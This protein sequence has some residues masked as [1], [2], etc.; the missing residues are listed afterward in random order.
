MLNRAHL[1]PW[2]LQH[3]ALDLQRRREQHHALHIT[4]Q[5]TS[6]RHPQGTPTPPHRLRCSPAAAS[7]AGCRTMCPERKIRRSRCE[8]LSE[9]QSN[10]G[11]DRQNQARSSR[12]TPRQ[13]RARKKACVQE[14]KARTKPQQEESK[15][16]RFALAGVS[17]A[18]GILPAMKQHDAGRGFHMS[19]HSNSFKRID[20]TTPCGELNEASTLQ[21][22]QNPHP[23]TPSFQH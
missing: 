18:C 17:R 2:Y 10:R 5:R 11:W 15:Q 13:R 9:W 23:P 6:H 21:K 1:S 8:L 20:R 16:R 22:Q 7:R 14:Q 12:R 19:K 4:L 3:E